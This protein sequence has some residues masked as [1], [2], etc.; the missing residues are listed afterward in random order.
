MDYTAAEGYVIF[1]VLLF[2]NGFLCVINTIFFLRARASYL[3]ESKPGW[4]GM[5]N[6]LQKFPMVMLIMNFYVV[7]GFVIFSCIGLFMEEGRPK[8]AL[9]Y[10]FCTIAYSK[11]LEMFGFV[12]LTWR[13]VVFLS[14]HP[15]S[16]AKFKNY[17]WWFMTW[18]ALGGVV[19]GIY[20]IVS[21]L[22]PENN[23]DLEKPLAREGPLAL[24]FCFQ[25]TV[26]S[27][28]FAVG[29]YR[30]KKTSKVSPELFRYTD[31]FRR[32]TQLNFL[33]LTS[34]I[35]LIFCTVIILV[36]TVYQDLVLLVL[37]I[38]F[39]LIPPLVIPPCVI[40]IVILTKA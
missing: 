22:N 20:S 39:F 3:P 19:L 16:E 15:T 2:Y 35:A 32:L 21:N 17:K 27:I 24:W 36:Q 38:I 7:F 11:F 8:Y 14:S 5:P 18:A 4:L 31:L 23:P 40:W 26:F 12:Y 13:E 9:L 34:L 33:F 6:Y 30:L 25:A 1:S 37:F 28:G 10:F 29:L